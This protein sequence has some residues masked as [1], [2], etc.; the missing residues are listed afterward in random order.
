M[1]EELLLFGI[2]GGSGGGGGGGQPFIGIGGGGGGGVPNIPL[3]GELL[4]DC[5][6]VGSSS[7][8]VSAS[9][10]RFFNVFT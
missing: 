3:S 4:I 9:S 1:M 8:F 10:A 6:G 7:N 5:E 2:N